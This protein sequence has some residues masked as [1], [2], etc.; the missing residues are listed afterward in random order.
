MTPQEFKKIRQD[1]GLSLSQ[2]SD[3]IKVH[4]RTIRRYENGSLNVSGPVSV[5]MNQ[6]KRSVY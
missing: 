3:L 1:A 2:L 6:I 4:T 5:L